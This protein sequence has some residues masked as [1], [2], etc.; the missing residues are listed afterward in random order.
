M[1][2]RFFIAAAGLCGAAGVGLSAMA[3]H[4]GGG[5]VGV[6]ANFLLF[7]A[8]VV[9]SIGLLGE[10]RRALDIAAFVLL[11]GVILFCGDLLARQYLGGVAGLPLAPTGGMLMIAGWLGIAVA[12]A[13]KR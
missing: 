5:N 8:P 13:L 12:G 3:A 4:V 6:A 9:L 7:H 11:A 1:G 10:S 2:K